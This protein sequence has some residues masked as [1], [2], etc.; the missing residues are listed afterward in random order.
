MTAKTQKKNSLYRI[1]R[2]IITPKKKSLSANININE[3]K[4]S[5]IITEEKKKKLKNKIKTNK[6]MLLLSKYCI[7]ITGCTIESQK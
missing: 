3:E 4:N 5:K 6:E 1:L 7:S 2:K